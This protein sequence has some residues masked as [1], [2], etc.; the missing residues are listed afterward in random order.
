[1]VP[2][3]AST[4][5]EWIIDS[6][7]NNKAKVIKLIATS[8]SKLT[9]SFDGWKANNDILDLLGVI[10]H[11]LRDDHKLHNVILAMRDTLGSHTGSNIAD[12]LFDVLKDYQISSN[13][14]TYFAADNTTNNDKVLKLLSERVTLDLVTSRLRYAGY[15]FNLV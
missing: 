8:I 14:I 5:R 3:A 12:H 13:Q 15:I 7:N 10:I 11:Y 1:V 4:T 6:Y 9:I 2:R